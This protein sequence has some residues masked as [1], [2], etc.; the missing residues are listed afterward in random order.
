MHV[1]ERLDERPV[2]HLLAHPQKRCGHLR[3]EERSDGA[4]QRVGDDLEILRAGVE[5]LGDG[6]VLEQGADGR[7]VVDGERV[8][9]G[10]L[11]MGAELDEAELGE[12]GL[13]AQEL[14]IDGED[15]GG[16]GTL[17]ECAE[18]LTILDIQPEL[19]NDRTRV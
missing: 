16:G 3:V 14:G 12:V 7:E 18:R 9:R 19:S 17:A 11:V 1:R 10:G 13:L 4:A 6:G 2:A 8:D 15:M 5:H